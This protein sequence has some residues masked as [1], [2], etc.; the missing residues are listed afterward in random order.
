MK[1]FEHRKK[2]RADNDSVTSVVIVGAEGRAEKTKDRGARWLRRE[3]AV[4]EGT[5]FCGPMGQWRKGR[6]N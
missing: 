3:M 1:E 2:Y 4:V 6:Y 5:G